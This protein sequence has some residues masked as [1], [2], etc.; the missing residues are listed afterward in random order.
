MFAKAT[1]RRGGSDAAGVKPQSEAGAL[2]GHRPWNG[3]MRVLAAARPLGVQVFQALRRGSIVRHNGRV[4]GAEH[5][6]DP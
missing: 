6:I 5:A 2:S 3:E 1:L 4:Q